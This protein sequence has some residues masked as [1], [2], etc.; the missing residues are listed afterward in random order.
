MP[1]CEEDVSAAGS[2]TV[3]ALKQPRRADG[4]IFREIKPRW[5]G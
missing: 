4:V 1:G 5:R 3:A 2:L